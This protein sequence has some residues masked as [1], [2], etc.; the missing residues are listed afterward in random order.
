MRPRGGRGERSP[1]VF[2][3]KTDKLGVGHVEVE[4]GSGKLECREKESPQQLEW[5]AGREREG[6]AWRELLH[7]SRELGTQARAWEG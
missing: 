2:V 4:V 6:L 7:L 1:Q 5:E 3:D